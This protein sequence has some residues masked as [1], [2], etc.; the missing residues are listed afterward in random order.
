[1]YSVLRIGIADEGLA[2]EDEEQFERALGLGKGVFW[3]W[4]E[5]ACLDL[6]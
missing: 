1:M 6:D 3:D 2:E 5:C 4:V